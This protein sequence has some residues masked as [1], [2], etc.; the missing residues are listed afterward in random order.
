MRWLH[1]DI[2]L[3]LGN[4]IFPRPTTRQTSCFSACFPRI[5]RSLDDCMSSTVYTMSCEANDIPTKPHNRPYFLF[6]GEIM[7]ICLLYGHC[8]HNSRFAC[9]SAH[10]IWLRSFLASKCEQ[11]FV[12]LSGRQ[13]QMNLNSSDCIV[14]CSMLFVH[15]CSFVRFVRRPIAT[16]YIC[17]RRT[18]YVYRVVL[19]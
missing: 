11:Y 19:G 6:D 17:H 10:E 13:N 18:Y 16:M 9:C 2:V 7:P 15:T 4:S 12:L 3:L 8:R 5:I 14:F 1:L